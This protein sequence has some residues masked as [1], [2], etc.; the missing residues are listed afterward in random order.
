MAITG[1]S[2][3]LKL[4][5]GVSYIPHRCAL[6]TLH[7]ERH[8]GTRLVAARAGASSGHREVG[9]REFCLV[10]G[11]FAQLGAFRMTLSS[12]LSSFRVLWWTY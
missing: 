3:Y 1:E 7:H 6:L 4:P 10:T 5:A 12:M 9:G 11:I 8:Y 2:S